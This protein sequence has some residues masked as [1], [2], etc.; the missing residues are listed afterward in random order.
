ML[1]DEEIQRERRPKKRIGRA[2]F[3]LE[4]LIAMAILKA[5]S[6][7]SI[8]PTVVL[9]IGLLIAIWA[10][11]K[12]LRD[13]SRRDWWL[14]FLVGL[15]ILIFVYGLF[16]ELN[17]VPRPDDTIHTNMMPMVIVVIV[18]PMLV[19]S[20]GCF[21]AAWASVK[22]LRDIKQSEWW[23]TILIA[24]VIVG[25]A[26]G[27]SAG[28]L[29]GLTTNTYL[30]PVGIAYL[31]V[32]LLYMGVL[33]FRPSAFPKDS[34]AVATTGKQPSTEGNAIATGVSDADIEERFGKQLDLVIDGGVI[35]AEHSSISDLT[36]E[37]P[38][39]IRKGKGDVSLFQ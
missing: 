22:R 11:A 5:S 36:D 28:L 24:P 18:I 34:G 4:F 13:I 6:S 37:F 26:Y 23:A 30:K 27:L 35:V 15:G 25:L 2:R 9:G 17:G 1:T 10:N 31:V 3:L 32:Y 8:V 39:V 7:D 12:R 16:C 20:L 29:G 33:L 21:L 14:P 19:L 38:K